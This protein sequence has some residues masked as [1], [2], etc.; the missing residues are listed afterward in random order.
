M[1]SYYQWMATHLKRGTNR[2]RQ[3]LTSQVVAGTQNNGA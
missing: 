3:A 1:D 2:R